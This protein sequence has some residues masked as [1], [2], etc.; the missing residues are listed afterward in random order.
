[1]TGYVSSL[2]ALLLKGAVLLLLANEVRGLVLAAPVLYGMY[3]AGGTW[4]ALWVG[5]C[6][7]AG[8]AVSVVAPLYIAKRFRLFELASPQRAR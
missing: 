5:F 2:A 6:T 3:E 8:I 4:M 1:M 7:L